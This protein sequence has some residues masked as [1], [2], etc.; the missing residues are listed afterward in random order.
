MNITGATNA[1]I[2][3]GIRGVVI[4][5]NDATPTLSITPVTGAEGGIVAF[6]ISMDRQS[7]MSPSFTYSLSGGTATSGTDY[8]NT[9]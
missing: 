1:T 3:L 9:G 7:Q 6:N 2:D 4:A 8:T 5:D